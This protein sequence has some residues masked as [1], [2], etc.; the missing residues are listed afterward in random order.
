M[1]VSQTYIAYFDY[2]HP[3]FKH[4]VLYFHCFRHTCNKPYYTIVATWNIL[5]YISSPYL[6]QFSNITSTNTKLYHHGPT[7]RSAQLPSLHRHSATS[8]FK[9]T[10]IWCWNIPWFL[11]FLVQG[12]GSDLVTL[13]GW[14][15]SK[16]EGYGE[17]LLCLRVWREW[18]DEWRLG[19]G[20]VNRW[21]M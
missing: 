5:C 6:S 17:C 2:Y 13:N 18:S 19:F 4:I 20:F 3:N 21:G 12:F 15:L 8:I 7:T 1:K 11:L 14:R 10:A 16:K 9:S